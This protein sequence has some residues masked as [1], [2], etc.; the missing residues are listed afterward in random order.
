VASRIAALL[1]A[2]GL[3]G[4]ATWVFLWDPAPSYESV[5]NDG[6]SLTG[7]NELEAFAGRRI[8]FGHMSVGNNI[9]SGL[10]QVHASHEVAPAPE[11]EIEPGEA[12]ALPPDGVLVHALIGEN[13]HPVRKLANFDATLRAGVAEQVEMAAL[14]FCYIDIRWNSDVE[15]LFARYQNTL[16]RL[17][18]DY[19]QVTFVHMTVPLTTGPYG[20]RDHLK[21]LAGRDDN[22]ARERYNDLVREAYGPDRVFDVAALEATPPD[23]GEGDR[24]LYGG[25]SSDG[26]HL[27]AA[28]SARIAA[29]FV[30]FVANAEP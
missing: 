17:E 4:A 2:F 13:R 27:N 25:Y 26:A 14:K 12:P 9:M 6:A 18:A 3:L 20:I 8:F 15:E 29:Q 21:L 22:A 7:R 23:G 24:E 16:A 10:E 19:P 30:E 5:A 11:I 1:A 28:G